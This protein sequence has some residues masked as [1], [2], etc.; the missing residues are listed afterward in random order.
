[1]LLDKDILDEKDKRLH[2][3]SKEVTFPMDE[4]DK[5]MIEDM[6]EHL[7]LSQIPEESEKYDLRPGMGLAAIQVGIPKRYFV[8]VYEID[9]G[10]FENY[11]MIN[12]KIVSFNATTTTMEEG[13]LSVLGADG[14]PVYANVTRPDGVVVEWTDET[15]TKQMA[16]MSGLPARIVQ[17]ET[18]HLDGKLFVDYLSPVRREMLMRKVRRKK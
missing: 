2:K 12:P 15:G 8:V 14:L 9:D 4:K 18:D 6:I 3:P 11:I 10:E 5:Q 16:Q 17:H 7:R 13:C 1:M